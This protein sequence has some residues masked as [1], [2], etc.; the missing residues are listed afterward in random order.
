MK[1]NNWMNNLNRSNNNKQ[2]ISLTLRMIVFVAVTISL[3]LFTINVVVLNVVEHHFKEQDADE[4]TVMNQSIFQHLHKLS[5]SKVNQGAM[6][7]QAVSGH[8][9]VYFQIRNA[10]G[11]IIYS[12]P[13]LSLSTSLSNSVSDALPDA[14]SNKSLNNSPIVEL[15]A[16][17]LW[18]S[19]GHTFRGAVTPYAIG[20]DSFII[21]TAIDMEFHKTFLQSF[22]RSLALVMVL[23]G[24]ATL[25]AVWF[26]VFQGLAPLRR[27]SHKVKSIE[28]DQLDFRLDIKSVPKELTGLVLAFNQMINGLEKSFKQLSHFSADIAHE[29]RTP[30]TNI[31]TQT[32]VGLSKP[33]DIEEYKNLLYSNLEEQERLAKMVND[34]LWLAKSDHGLVKPVLENIDL[35][36][37]ISDLFEFFEA[38]AEEQDIELV[39]E[40]N[41]LFIQ[42]DRSMLRQAFSNL[43]SNA[44]RHTQSGK[45]IKVSIGNTHTHPHTHA[46]ISFENAGEHIAKEHL[47]KLFDRFYRVDP[48]RQR[49]S[50]GAGLGLSIVKSIIES[51]KGYTEAVSK[52][53]VIQFIVY[54]P[55]IGNSAS[56]EM[57]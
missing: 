22:R 27:L 46:L 34:M 51:H 11:D 10:L 14:G 43:L 1:M 21:I 29:L 57:Y 39:L 12:S 2:P 16:L 4:L 26:G 56:Q 36:Q 53:G 38:L 23:A 44:L 5:A 7:S 49:N 50:D 15:D 41:S 31:I 55:N 48:A 9:G 33:R 30:L 47:E 40:G 18:E 19:N 13:E 42:G 17:Q 37:E 8:H 25:L 32:Q 52:K 24:I 35:R 54:I 28:A 6:L 20:S 3:C 45:A